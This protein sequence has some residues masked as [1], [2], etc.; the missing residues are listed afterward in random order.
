[1]MLMSEYLWNLFFFVI[2]YDIAL[3]FSE[4]KSNDEKRAVRSEWK[5]VNIDGNAT[6][7]WRRVI[8]GTKT[9]IPF[10]PK[11]KEPERESRLLR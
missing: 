10:P 3:F 11:P 2:K 9:I 5:K 6:I 4:S 7:R 8:A 1:M